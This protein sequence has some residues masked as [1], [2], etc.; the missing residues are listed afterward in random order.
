MS[1]NLEVSHTQLSNYSPESDRSA[2]PFTDGGRAVQG[3]TANEKALPVRGGV[4]NMTR[5]T[6]E[7]FVRNVR[8]EQVQGKVYIRLQWARAWCAVEEGCVYL[9]ITLANVSTR[10]ANTEREPLR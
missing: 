9:Y 7:M 8:M 1:T 2:L 5:T 10:T 3:S 6:A 4:R